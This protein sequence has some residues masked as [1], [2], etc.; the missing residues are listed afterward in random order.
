VYYVHP[1]SRVT[2]ENQ[3]DINSEEWDGL[4]RWWVDHRLRMVVMGGDEHEH[5]EK[6]LE[7]ARQRR[8]L[9]FSLRKIVSS[10]LPHCFG[11]YMF[12]KF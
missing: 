10:V 7:K 6:D 5:V 11:L 1:T 2:T 9:L 4:E 3:S 12:S 8:E